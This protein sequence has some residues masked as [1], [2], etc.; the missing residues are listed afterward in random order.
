MMDRRPFARKANRDNAADPA[1]HRLCQIH[2]RRGGEQL[3]VLRFREL[4]GAPI[5]DQRDLANLTGMIQCPFDG[6]TSGL[7]VA[8]NCI[9]ERQFEA[10]FG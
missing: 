5:G 4:I 1:R 2:F 3:A 6:P 7:L 9:V 8:S 10:A